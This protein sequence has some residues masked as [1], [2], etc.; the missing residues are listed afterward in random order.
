MFKI[1]YIA[2]LILVAAA[3]LGFFV[4]KTSVPG[5]SLNFKLG[6]DLSGGT[7][8]TYS[9]DTSNIPP[10]EL[11]DSLT[12]LQTVI[13]RRVN[14]FGVGEP[15]VA[16][17]QGGALG[18]GDHRLIVELPGVTNINDA[19]NRI[20]QTPLLEFKLVKPGFE[21]STTDA[22]GNPNPAAFE[23]TGLTGAYLSGSQLQFGNGSSVASTPTVEITFN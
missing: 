18:T 3:A 11:K 15:V 9:A 16:L 19:I 10:S 2:V 1:R 4:Y 5:N 6:L 22:L 13:E 21:A 14:A 20:G 17:E 12:A 7:E 23:D 8:L